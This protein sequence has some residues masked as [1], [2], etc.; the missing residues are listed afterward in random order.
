MGYLART[1]SLEEG[2]LQRAMV[3]GS[4]VASFVVEQFS[5]ERLKT[6]T[7]AEIVERCRMFQRITAFEI[8]EV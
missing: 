8:G 4:A 2:A 5:V 3:Y 6:L 1:G 7:Y